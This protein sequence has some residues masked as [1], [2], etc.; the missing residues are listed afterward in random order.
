MANKNTTYMKFLYLG[1]GVL[2]IISGL[3]FIIKQKYVDGGLG[4]I[5]GSF[6]IYLYFKKTG[7]KK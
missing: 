6:V 7:H 3:Y 1:I 4:I 5:I 2:S